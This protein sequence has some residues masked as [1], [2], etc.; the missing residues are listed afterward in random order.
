MRAWHATRK[1]GAW[2]YAAWGLAG[3]MIHRALIFLE[4]NRR[5]KGPAWRY[6]EGPGPSFFALATVLHGAIAA[7]VTY[8]TADAGY[9]HNP[10]LGLGLGI[11]APTAV[12]KISSLALGALPPTESPNLIDSEES[13]NNSKAIPAVARAGDDDEAAPAGGGS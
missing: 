11:A 9:I 5:T 1:V 8:V 4:A 13:A 7:V 10:L 3:A 12:K 6:P 2:Q